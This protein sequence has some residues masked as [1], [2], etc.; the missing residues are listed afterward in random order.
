MRIRRASRVLAP[1]CVAGVIL[2]AAG[3][4]RAEEHKPVLG[5][6][7]P[8]PAPQGTTPAPTP[9]IASGVPPAAVEG[10]IERG[11]YLAKIGGCNDC[12]TPLKLGATGPEP[13]MERMLSGHPENLQMP[14]PPKLTEPW[15]TVAASTNTAFAGPWGVSYATNL[16]PDKDTGMGAWTEQIF[17]TTMRTGKHWGVA[18]PILPPMPW[19]NIARLNDDDLGSLY[20]YLTSIPAIKNRVPEAAIA[21]K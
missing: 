16:T 1:A 19:P 12:H 18:R 14:P 5:H 7:A 10:M 11:A 3:A 20:R 15:G 6:E 13:D 9:P 17:V 2:L 4:A 21:A 8:A